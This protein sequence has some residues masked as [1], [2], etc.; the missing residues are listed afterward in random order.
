MKLGGKPWMGAILNLFVY[1]SADIY[2]GSFRTGLVKFLCF[3]PIAF[4]AVVLLENTFDGVL[5]GRS[6]FH[7]Q[8]L[9]GLLYILFT[10]ISGYQTVSRNR[11]AV[12]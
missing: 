5:R 12:K 3:Y 11:S 7:M 2:V 8:Q 4:L 10:T 6:F 1:G 9:L